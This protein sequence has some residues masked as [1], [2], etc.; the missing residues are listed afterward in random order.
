MAYVLRAYLC[1]GSRDK[2][3]VWSARPVFERARALPANTRE[4]AHLAA[5][6]SV[7]ADDYERARSQLGAILQAFPRDV[8]AL[9]IVHSFDY[10][11]GDVARLRDRVPG[12]LPAW[13]RHVPGYHAVLAMQAFGLE[14]GGEYGRAE[15]VG[16]H[17]LELNPFDARAHHAIA[18]VFEMTGRAEAG[19]H[20]MHERVGYWAADTLVST[21]CWWHLALH[22]LELGQLDRAIA[23]YDQRVR[24]GHSLEVA[25]LIDA[26][27]LLWRVDLA[28][29]GAGD[30][31]PQD[32]GD[33]DTRWAELADVWAPHIEDRFCS[34]NDLHAMLAFV[35]ANDWDRA[36]RLER[37]LA[38][39]RLVAG[40]HGET[41]R[42]VGLAACRGLLAFGGGE[43]AEAISLLGSLPRVAH[44]FGGSH[45]QRDVLQLTLLHA[46]E[47]Y[48]RPGRMGR[49]MMAA[50]A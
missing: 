46:V 41:T 36:L 38:R 13:S 16:L 44:R 8:L 30:P 1:L 32:D 7:L 5:I 11:G 26:A 40:R 10:A 29:R 2:V 24:A 12:V 49:A 19:V 23:I 50:A 18:H 47:G 45:A 35:G 22:H 4:R 3:R 21:H 6:E 14:E 15:E 39:A 9:Q 28:L 20:W 34:F 42:H 27:A 17:A 48:R 31:R 33:L 43:Y 25:D 37:E